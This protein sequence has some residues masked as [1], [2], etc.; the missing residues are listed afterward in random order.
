MNSVKYKNDLYFIIIKDE[1]I[2]IV[3]FVITVLILRIYD[4]YQNLNSKWNGNEIIVLKLWTLFWIHFLIF[5]Q[6]EECIGFITICFFIHV[7]IFLGCYKYLEV[8]PIK[9]ID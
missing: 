8:E 6:N 9:F 5:E 1:I 7:I 2:C 3:Y 4:F